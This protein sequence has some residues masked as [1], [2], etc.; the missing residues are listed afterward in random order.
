VQV[1]ALACR[2]ST[3]EQDV[4]VMVEDLHERVEH[5]KELSSNAEKFAAFN[6]ELNMPEV[7]SLYVYTA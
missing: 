6:K 3:F 7:R 1:C 2:Y 5:M 4:D